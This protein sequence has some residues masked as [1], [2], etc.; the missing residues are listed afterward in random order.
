MRKKYNIKVKLNFYIVVFFTHFPGI[1]LPSDI[2]KWFEHP[3]AIPQVRQ[4]IAKEK[5]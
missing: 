3:T 4:L 5:H 1:Y 2:V